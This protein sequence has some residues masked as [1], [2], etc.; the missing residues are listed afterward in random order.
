ML[1]FLSRLWCKH[2]WQVIGIRQI[3][4]A[5]ASLSAFLGGNEYQCTKC[6]KDL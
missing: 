2:D 4:D 5:G 1:K 6:G 3:G